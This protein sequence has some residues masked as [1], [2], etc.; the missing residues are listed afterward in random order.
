MITL[1]R[2]TVW[3]DNLRKRPYRQAA[4]R[5]LSWAITGHNLP[6]PNDGAVELGYLRPMAL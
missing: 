3:P 4:S 5:L 6:P 1:N 2:G